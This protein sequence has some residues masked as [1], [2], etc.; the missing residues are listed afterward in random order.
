MKS[1]EPRRL[2]I[3]I[4]VGS[5]LFIAFFIGIV[6]FVALVGLLSYQIS[7][8][9]ITKQAQNS[10][11]QTIGKT[12]DNVAMVFDNIA[13]ASKKLAVDKTFTDDAAQLANSTDTS[14]RTKLINAIN[15]M[16]R[17]AKA[18][19]DMISTVNILF[20]G[21]GVSSEGRGIA[22]DAYKADWVAEAAKANGQ[23]V[24]FAP[25]G[26]GQVFVKLND[27]YKT[28]PSVA[29]ARL[30]RNQ[31]TGEDVGVLAI[32][33][34]LKSLQAKLGGVDGA[35][36]FIQ[37]AGGRYVY[38]ADFAK[39]AQASEYAELKR[40]SA[41]LSASSGRQL[42]AVYPLEGTD[43]LLG[44][45]I[46]VNLLTKDTVKIAQ[47]T[48]FAAIAAAAFAALVGWAVVRMIARPITNMT[49]LM[50]RAASGDLT[51]RAE[52]GRRKDEIGQLN[53]HF[54]EMMSNTGALIRETIES[55]AAVF[56]TAASVERASLQNETSAG[57]IAESTRG[58][59][60]GSAALA[61][62]AERGVEL[63]ERIMEGVARV[64]ESNGEMER[65]ADEVRRV[66]EEGQ[67][68]L[69]RLSE[70]T[71]QVEDA[72]RAINDRMEVLSSQTA[73]V[74]DLL[75]QLNRLARQTNI[76][77]LNASIEA[78]RVGA[79][80]KGFQVI[81]QEMGS[82]AKESEKHLGR[83]ADWMQSMASDITVTSEEM[84]RARPL[85]EQQFGAIV[86]TERLFGQIDDRMNQL[87]VSLHDGSEKVRQ[88]EEAQRSLSETI[89]NVGA[90]SEQS[91][92]SVQEVAAR[93]GEQAG[94]SS[95]LTSD[96]KRLASLAERLKEQLVRFRV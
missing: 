25:K 16:F 36:L 20:E 43:W 32:E 92:A 2:R 49:K 76:L 81:A 55:A 47:V 71:G 45:A 50:E 77:S 38:D 88:M 96:A 83:V 82:L 68:H 93:T 74:T 17:S 1:A 13:S 39:L 53:A 6:V 33:V 56:E 29:L 57:Q 80:G 65:K 73:S 28:E 18:D 8:S 3:G 26:D 72:N 46:P 19:S 44:G 70:T 42:V 27:N 91:T 61:A 34:K 89:M 5:K 60:E 90:V 22:A 21:G 62:D 75:E 35:Q 67:T 52:A 31:K 95:R 40:G 69:K 63:A 4:S 54:N 51:G 23:P 84:V 79:A 66:G 86:Q 14:E 37:D 64:I 94:I 10:F 78:S 11:A 41:K 58:I 9:I 7:E 24:W 48:L 87:A 15:V 30:I 12:G 59:S 85:F